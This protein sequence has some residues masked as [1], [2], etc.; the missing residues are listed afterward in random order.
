MPQLQQF[1]YMLFQEVNALAGHV[2]LLDALM[3]FSANWLIFFYLL[4]L[5]LAWG[6]PLNWRKRLVGVDETQSIYTIRSTILWTALACALA[7]VLNLTIEQFVFEPRPF[8]SHRVHL[9]VTHAA[10]ASFPSDHSAWAFAVVGMFLFAFLPAL[11]AARK[12]RSSRK[13]DVGLAEPYRLL[14]VFLWALV[15]ACCIGF[16]RV[17]V[18]IHYPGDILGGAIDGLV[19]ATLVTLLR[20]WLDRP[21]RAVLRFAQKMRLA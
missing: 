13:P 7:Y 2:S 3:I 10:D 1:N 5:L 14:W 21:T 19:A 6:R 17:Y 4:L 11:M 20:R 15:L 12:K 16:A 18:G 9:L 8:I